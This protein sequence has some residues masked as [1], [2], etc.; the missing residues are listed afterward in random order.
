MIEQPPQLSF[1]EDENAC[2]GANCNKLIEFLSDTYESSLTPHKPRSK[3]KQP[4]TPWITIGLLRSINTRDKLCSKILKAKNLEQRQKLEK[5]LRSFKKILRRTCNS[6]K[7]NYYTNLF[8]R[9]K[10]DSR[11]MWTI[12]NS[13]I[14]NKSYSNN[15]PDSFK[16]NG[17]FVS[18]TKT[19]AN[20]SISSLP[21]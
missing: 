2:P 8:E 12:I 20:E 7:N 17:D 5:E 21:V 11:K 6:A 19:I 1:N 16:I 14:N 3:R 15:F 18:D 13:L 4:R 10:N 9:Y